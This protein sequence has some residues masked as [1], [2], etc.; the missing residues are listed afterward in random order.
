M[1]VS[2]LTV[3]AGICLSPTTEDEALST[4]SPTTTFAVRRW[5]DI[6]HCPRA[7]GAQLMKRPS[8][9]IMTWRPLVS[10]MA[11]ATV[12]LTG[13]MS[14][15]AYDPP[16]AK[17]TIN[18]GDWT[19]GPGETFDGDGRGELAVDENGCIYLRGVTESQDLVWPAD[20]AVAT[21]IR[22]RPVVTNA[23]GA[24]LKVGKE[25]SLVGKVRSLDAALTCQA[26]V[27]SG[28]TAFYV[29]DSIAMGRTGPGG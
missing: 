4:F 23:A 8:I 18:V 24:E 16:A 10:A 22:S 12:A 28:D 2:T 13:C 21:D 14:G 1:S 26:A 5:H 29:V 7:S 19:S 3:K 9:P 25:V 6:G 17:P 20:Y 27:G 15:N 11:A